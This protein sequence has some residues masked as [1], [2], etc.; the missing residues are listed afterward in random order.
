MP[1]PTRT[2]TP[3]EERLIESQRGKCPCVG[4][5]TVVAEF[6]LQHTEAGKSPWDPGETIKA[7]PGQTLRIVL[8]SRMGDIGLTADLQSAHGYT[9]RLDPADAALTDIRSNP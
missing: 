9:V 8:F 2:L 7:K 5:A 6:P 3:E 4:Y 1:R